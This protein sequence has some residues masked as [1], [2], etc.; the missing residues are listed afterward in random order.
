MIHYHKLPVIQI[1]KSNSSIIYYNVPT[2][3][4][5]I[6]R[7]GS[8]AFICISII[9]D[10]Q[11]SKYLLGMKNM[12]MIRV[13]KALSNPTRLQILEWLKEPTKYF[14]EV[15]EDGVCVSDIQKKVQLSQ[16]TVSQ[17][18][19]LLQDVGLIQATRKGQWTFYKRDEQQID[20]IKEQIIKDI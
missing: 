5:R 17:Y 19:S 12:E 18:L 11:Y 1:H 2:N 10:I 7:T 6:T 16:S 15:Y 4:E 9:L 8:N 13:Y 3:L 14:T 20:T